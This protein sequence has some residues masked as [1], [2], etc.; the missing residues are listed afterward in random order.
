MN[1]KLKFTL[2]T[3]LK[4]GGK[5][6]KNGYGKTHSIR[7]KS[8]VSLVT[9]TDMAADRAI[10]KIILK[11]FPDHGLLTEEQ[12]AV[13]SRSPYRWIIDPLDGTTNFAHNIPFFCVSIGLEY[14]GEIVIGGIYNP[15]L[16]ELFFAEK[17]KG[18]FLNGKRIHVSKTGSL[19]DS[20]L[21]TGFPY[22]RQ[23]KA[24]YYLKF[25]QAFMQKCRGVRRLGAA[26]IDLA[27]VAC[28]R[29]EGYWEFNLKPWDMAAGSLIVAEAG[30]R[31]TNFRGGRVNVSLPA[32]TLASNPN[33]H[34]KL[35][36]V[37]S[38]SL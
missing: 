28:G 18:A 19:I 27:Y 15:V 17:G 36:K 37:L 12:D 29:F 33:I 20:L 9:E 21:V 26:A 32:Q 22:D 2:F 8:A 1:P 10:R 6:I 3:C 16:S 13:K 31:V 14:Q 35:V 4:A 24:K 7:K 25:V 23:K 34:K 30:G 11:A 5:I 38:N